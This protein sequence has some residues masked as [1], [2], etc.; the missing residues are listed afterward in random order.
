MAKTFSLRALL[1]VFLITCVFLT[2]HSLGL[3]TQEKRVHYESK[4]W[5]FSDLKL[6]SGKPTLGDFTIVWM[7]D[8]NG[9]PKFGYL[10]IGKT[11]PNVSVS[12]TGSVEIKGKRLNAKSGDG[13]YIV[14]PDFSL[15]K[16]DL[17]IA[18]VKNE[19]LVLLNSPNPR[20]DDT[21]VYWPRTI[22]EN[23]DVNE[24]SAWNED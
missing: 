13:F 21:P 19:T 24:L 6:A 11:R 7:E 17:D 15:T 22:L 8:D 1:I 4:A 5:L 14:A 10:I 2:A 16:T 18:R 3:F 9:N 23:Y 12:N 20:S